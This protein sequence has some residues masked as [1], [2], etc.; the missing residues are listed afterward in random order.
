[1]QRL[2]DSCR[3]GGRV[4]ECRILEALQEAEETL[5][6]PDIECAEEH[7]AERRAGEKQPKPR[8]ER[9]A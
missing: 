1:M 7:C 4:S 3:G 9:R 6:G 5:A 8:R 2:A